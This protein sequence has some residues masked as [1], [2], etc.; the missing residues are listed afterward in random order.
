M[1]V[2]D[3]HDSECLTLPYPKVVEQLRLVG[4]GALRLSMKC[5]SLRVA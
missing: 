1:I 2:L 4:A 5:I 3:F